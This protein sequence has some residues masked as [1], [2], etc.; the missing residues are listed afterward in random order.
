MTFLYIH[1]HVHGITRYYTVVASH[2]CACI[3]GPPVYLHVTLKNWEWPGD[4]ASNPNV[5]IIRY[6]VAIYFSVVMR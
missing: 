2:M 6:P 1:V 3:P 5:V 4:K